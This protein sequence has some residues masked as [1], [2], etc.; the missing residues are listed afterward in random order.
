MS[1]STID[2]GFE[3]R[4]HQQLIYKSL[5]RFNVLVCH[6]RFGKTFLCIFNILDQAFRCPL[7]NPQYAYFAPTYAQAK[8]VAWTILKD[9]VKNVPGVSTH[10]QELRMV[11]ER[12][13][14]GDKIFIYLLSAENP[15]SHRGLYLDGAVLD[16]YGDCAPSLWGKVVRPALT[17]RHVEAKEKGFGEDN[18]WAIFIGTPKGQNH[19]FDLFRMAAAN[20]S[21]YAARFKASQTRIIPSYEL[22]ELKKEQSEDEYEQEFEC[23]F[24]A[25]LTGAYYAKILNKMM[26][27]DKFT[28]VPY[29]PAL[30]VDTYWD[31]GIG[32]STAI[33]FVQNYRGLEYRII[34]YLENSGEG[35]G[36]YCDEL[37]KKGYSYGEIVLPHD[38][39]A[40][41]LSTGRSRQQQI[42]SLMG[43]NPRVLK[44]EK[45][46][47]RIHAVRTILPKCIFDQVKTERGVACLMNYSRKFD[48]KNQIFSSKPVHNWASHGSD[49]FGYFAQ[50]VRMPMDMVQRRLPTQADIVYT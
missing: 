24:A 3:P 11:I 25:A 48:E 46:E 13:W 29:D 50:G 17:D 2:L 35:L 7:K 9:A 43:I 23:S 32:D 27:E 38:G 6:R 45:I 28:S 40:R 33:W 36:W 14:M 1:D 31:L 44:R 20:P 22:L 30:P 19:F 5:K 10:E 18:G 26:D 47:D 39:A 37:K 42:R 41:D 8:K 21:W 12:P 16:E 49:A 15:D 34:D 4:P